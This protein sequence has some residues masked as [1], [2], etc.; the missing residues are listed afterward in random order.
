MRKI[1]FVC[2]LL[3]VAAA[4]VV[5]YGQE[6][7][8]VFTYEEALE[9]ALETF[10]EIQDLENA[11]EELEDLRDDLRDVLALTYWMIAYTRGSTIRSHLDEVERQIE[12]L[13]LDIRVIELRAE[14]TLRNMLSDIANAA[15]DIEIMEASIVV[16]EESLRRANLLYSLGMISTSE[17]RR[18]ESRIMQEEMSLDNL[19]L[20]MANSQAS[21]N[22]LLGQSPYQLTIVE[23]E[24]TQSE[25]PVNL[26]RHI[27]QTVAQ[28]PAIRQTQINTERQRDAYNI[29]K[30]RCH[31]S[32]WR[33]CDSCVELHEAYARARLD[34]SLATR[35]MET[36]LRMAHNRMS[37]LRT[38]EQAGSLE[39]LQAVEG[40]ETAEIN[41][42]LG[43]GIPFE[44]TQARHEVLDAELNVKRFLY[45]QWV[46]D[47]T[48]ANPVLL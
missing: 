42:E 26:T 1:A 13:T 44:I 32:P 2:A 45:R 3:L 40:L 27:T 36:A 48:L 20:V 5:V 29:H 39:L 23:Y 47:F 16:S 46:L 37:Q 22:L 10:P 19:R 14:L 25:A 24:I 15:I 43:R 9:L 12:E 4:S 6:D 17:R 34:Q 18:A 33:D 31:I 8:T 7:Y 21:L 38:Q 28:A 35:T 30:E 11:I 41:L